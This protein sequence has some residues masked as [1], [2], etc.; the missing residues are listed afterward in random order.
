MSNNI[1]G[2]VN[3][4]YDAFDRMVEQ[5]RGTS[6]TQIVYGADGSKLALT[7]GQALNKAFIPLPG[8]AKAIYTSGPTLSRYWHPD[9]LGSVRL[10]STPTQTVLGE[11]AYAPYG[12]THA[13][14]GSPDISF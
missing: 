5:A 12:E 8:G 10:A 14:S 7:N 9:W 4:T 11:T 13:P 6:Y 2:N 3:L 1:N